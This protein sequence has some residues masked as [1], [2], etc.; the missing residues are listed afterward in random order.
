MSLPYEPEPLESLRARYP[1]AIAPLYDIIRQAQ[2]YA[3]GLATLPTLQRKH[4]FD[5]LNGL[6]LII[7]RESFISFTAIHISASALPDGAIEQQI[8]S[9]A[10]S[11]EAFF[12]M[13]IKEWQQISGSTARPRLVRVSPIAR[14]H[15]LLE[16]RH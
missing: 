11:Q 15:F 12:E 5:C 2:L 8:K 16:D 4:V 6:R 3:A 14:P 1:A 13:V 9:G 7:D 10:L